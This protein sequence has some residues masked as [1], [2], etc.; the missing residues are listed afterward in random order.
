MAL[1]RADGTERARIT[2]QLRRYEDRL[3]DLG[4]VGSRPA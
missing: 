4:I 3:V 1:A 2:S